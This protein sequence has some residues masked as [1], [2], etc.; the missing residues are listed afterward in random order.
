MDPIIDCVNEPD[1]EVN[2]RQ[3]QRTVSQ[4]IDCLVVKISQT[5]DATRQGGQRT[6][7]IVNIRI[8]LQVGRHLDD[9]KQR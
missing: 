1:R 9:N 2:K 4:N 8:E 3:N 5:F 6:V 7:T